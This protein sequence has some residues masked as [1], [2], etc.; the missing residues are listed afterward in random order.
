[1]LTRPLPNVAGLEVARRADCVGRAAQST[2]DDAV[3]ESGST[4]FMKAATPAT[5]A[6]E[7]EVP[8]R[9]E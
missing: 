3:G 8:L 2:G 1:M 5:I 7:A 9:V 6:D 4:A